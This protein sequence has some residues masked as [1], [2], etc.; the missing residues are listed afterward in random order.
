MSG[1]GFTITGSDLFSGDFAVTEVASVATDTG[2]E[3]LSSVEAASVFDYALSPEEV[4]SFGTWQQ[5]GD[6]AGDKIYNDFF[7]AGG[8]LDNP[9]A[10]ADFTY[11]EFF[12]QG[13]FI[14]GADVARVPGFGDAVAGSVGAPVFDRVG[15]ITP[16]EVARNAA[17]AF[18]EIGPGPGPG[19][20]FSLTQVAS[21]VQTEF[22]NIGRGLQQAQQV[23]NRIA[24]VANLV[25]GILRTPNPLAPLSGILNQA[26][27]VV[28]AGN[29]VA[30]LAGDATRS[31]RPTTSTPGP[32]VLQVTPDGAPV[33]V[34]T[35][36]AAPVP[37]DAA[38]VDP[39]GPL[40]TPDGAIEDGV[41][42]DTGLQEPPT[43]VLQNIQEGAT[44]FIR[45]IQDLST[46][47]QKSA[48]LVNAVTAAL[49]IPNPFAQAG[50]ALGTAVNV[51]QAV[52]AVA[53]LA[54]GGANAR[55]TTTPGAVSAP[56][57]RISYDTAI[58]YRGELEQD[59]IRLRNERN[60]IV[61]KLGENDQ[62]I[63]NLES[64]LS[65]PELTQA[66][67]D[68]IA[69]E[70]IVLQA[71]NGELEAQEAEV[72]GTLTETRQQL[73]NANAV[74]TQTNAS[75]VPGAAAVPSAPGV[76]YATVYNPTTNTWSVYDSVTGETAV[77]GLSEQ[78][79]RE[80]QTRF[81][82]TAASIALNSSPG[83]V[84]AQDPRSVALTAAQL[85]AQLAQVN[86]AAGGNIVSQ[87]NAVT[88]GLT[89]AARNQ[90]AIRSLRNNKA[91]SSD[92][93]VRL[94]LAPNSNY[95]YNEPGIG[96]NGPVNGPGIM[97]ALRATDG[98]VFPYT[99]SIETAYKANYEAYDLTH[100][101]YRGYFY[102]NSYV[103]V[104]N[105]R[106]TFTA[107]DT[108][109]ANYL[110]AVI[111]FFRSATKMFY[112]QDS[113]RGA[114]PPLVYLNGYGNY[115]FNEHP[116]VISQ[117]NY[118]LPPDVDYIR[119]Q[120]W[121]NNNTNLQLAR[122]RNPIANNPLAYSVNRLLNSRLLPGAKDSRPSLASNLA[123][124]EPT[125]VPTK[126][127]ISISL[128]PIQSRAQVSQNFS[129]KGFA[130]GNLLK[131]GY[132]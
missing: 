65:N 92:W 70:L 35:S 63:R 116:C 81:A 109:E 5:A 105:L 84:G 85:A 103:D 61:I 27:A 56:P 106:A 40:R 18:G 72:R 36:D 104:I 2:V 38:P 42:A 122:L 93:R 73:A 69:R 82:I 7:N 30:G 127:E 74:I 68:E 39:F 37:T 24:P 87:S 98:V 25:S 100:S 62:T 20:G 114:P 26:A 86:N 80:A 67:R 121:L 118:N 47:V 123:D 11:N 89:D 4:A 125:Y 83:S 23:V 45:S 95:L 31:L 19:T 97:A 16:G 34:L 130:D 55:P 28:Q 41:R 46:A 44:G 124:G 50:P 13:G 117:F 66:E 32:V 126:M 33:R 15:V 131:G 64:Q 17:L 111:H 51:A 94:R 78:Q 110:L 129:V 101:N 77:S 71:E 3:L 120:S 132:W 54:T 108:N 96:P 75:A 53:G 22:T 59:E 10:V 119:C 14:S 107:Q 6:L 112:G 12:Q 8:F 9:A 76:Q 29:A 90:A 88:A 52:G 57:G 79:A 1:E 58:I 113:L 21:Q 43:N 91:Q 48:P 115:Q 99:P 102:R 49:G 60:E 128:L